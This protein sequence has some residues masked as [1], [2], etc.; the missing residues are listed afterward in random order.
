MC[1]LGS[2]VVPAHRSLA[3]IP[4]SPALLQ[5]EPVA[6]AVYNHRATAHTQFDSMKERECLVYRSELLGR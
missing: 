4:C 1:S 5:P 3:G 6:V 2:N